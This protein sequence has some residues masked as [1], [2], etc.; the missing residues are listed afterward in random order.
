MKKIVQVLI[1]C[2]VWNSLIIKWGLKG[3]KLPKAWV[4]ASKRFDFKPKYLP[5][6]IYDNIH[7]LYS[8]IIITSFRY[9][10]LS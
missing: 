3:K 4:K 5:N 8:N 7:I 9:H 2:I 6:V 1:I 10:L